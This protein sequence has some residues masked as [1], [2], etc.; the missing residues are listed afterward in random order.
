MGNTYKSYVSALLIV[1][2]IATRAQGIYNS[3]ARIVSES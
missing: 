3:G 1:I 2:S